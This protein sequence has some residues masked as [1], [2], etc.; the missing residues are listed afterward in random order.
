MSGRGCVLSCVLKALKTE[1]VQYLVKLLESRME[2]QEN[3][4][5]VKAQVVNALKAM[6]RS[7][8]YG[9]QVRGIA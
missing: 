2:Q 4:S 1:T 9:E 8:K 3:P 7:L 5:A 6:Q